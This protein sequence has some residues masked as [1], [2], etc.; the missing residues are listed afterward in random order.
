MIS[1]VRSAIV[2][3]VLT[4]RPLPHGDASKDTIQLF[5]IL[6]PLSTDHGH[7]HGPDAPA[8]QRHPS[9]LDLR[10]PA[11][12]AQHA[13]PDSQRL[14]HIKVR[15]AHM[16]GNNDS[17][18]PLWQYIARHGDYPA[19]EDFEDALDPVPIGEGD[20]GRR[21]V[22]PIREKVTDWQEGRED[23]VHDDQVERPWYDN[24]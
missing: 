13:S 9:K 19:I 3:F 23:Q 7:A 6:R 14:D 1:K 5:L 2:L 8:Q 24:Q 12:P 4:G 15:P 18:F 21:V 11:A 16:V 22:D 10:K 17:R 20:E